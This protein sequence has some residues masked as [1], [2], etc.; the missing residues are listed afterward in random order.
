MQVQI[1]RAPTRHKVLVEAKRRLGPDPLIL[2]VRKQPTKEG[3]GFEW[4]A[5]VARETPAKVQSTV[6]GHDAGAI[7]TMEELTALR[8]RLESFQASPKS[9]SVSL[10]DLLSIARRLTTMEA[11]LLSQVL[12]ERGLSKSWQPLF[13]RLIKAGYPRADAPEGP[14]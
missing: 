4:E 7:K 5:V 8:G 6:A 14:L 11:N 13:D 3:D 12:D 9:S 2:S 1:V 10:S